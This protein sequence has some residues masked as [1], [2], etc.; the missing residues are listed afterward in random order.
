[1]YTMSE[2]KKY[3][4]QCLC[5]HILE[6]ETFITLRSLHLYNELNKIVTHTVLSIY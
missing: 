5:S 2:I 6:Y 4:M 1:M 3:Y